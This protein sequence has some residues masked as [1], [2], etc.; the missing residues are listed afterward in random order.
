MKTASTL[1]ILEHA[2]AWLAPLARRLRRAPRQ[3]AAPVLAEAIERAAEKPCERMT[4]ER[5]KAAS[6]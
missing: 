3:Q 4:G 6:E 2:A 5:H 1:A